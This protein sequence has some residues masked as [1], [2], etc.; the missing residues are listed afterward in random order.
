M[1]RAV[2]FEMQESFAW[3]G[4]TPALIIISLATVIEIVSN[5]IPW[6][7]NVLKMITTPVSTIAGIIIA[8]SVL[9]GMNP[10]FQWT[11]GVLAGGGLS[12]INHLNG[13][14]IRGASTA[15]TGGAANPLLT[16]VET[17]LSAVTSFLAFIIPIVMG[18]V[19]VIFTVIAV[20]IVVS[21]VKKIKNKKTKHLTMQVQPI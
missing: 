18:I 16:I 2:F 21:L 11:F 17:L 4:S 19:L 13:I 7:D 8:C 14:C 3:I 5:L 10:A 9:D 1:S 6:L 20:I 15:F 12:T